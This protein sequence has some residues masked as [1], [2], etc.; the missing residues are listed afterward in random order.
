[1]SEME[2]IEKIENPDLMQ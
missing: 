1:M 2:E